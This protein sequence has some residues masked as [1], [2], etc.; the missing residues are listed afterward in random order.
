M[1][2]L[3]GPGDLGWIISM[4][5]SVY[6]REFNFNSI[7]ELDIARKAISLCEKDDGF[8]KIWI[9]EVDNKNAGSIAISEID[10]DI[11]FIN[12]LLVLEEYRG[13]GIAQILIKHAIEYGKSNGYKFIRLETYSC[14]KSARKIY[15]GLGFKISEKVK[16]V[17]KYGQKFDQEFWQLSLIGNL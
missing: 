10:K 5:G 8:T 4:H 9:K 15:D 14:L 17:E 2:K 6:S 3:K 12:F 1:I 11:A 16:K 13:K 7:F